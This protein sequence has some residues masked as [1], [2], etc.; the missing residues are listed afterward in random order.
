MRSLAGN[1]RDMGG[2]PWEA[3]EREASVFRGDFSGAI[4]A[5][6]EALSKACVDNR[7]LG[8]SY[9]QGWW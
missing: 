8:F 4:T 5:E 7:G 6:G 2:G 9:N 1:E 3:P